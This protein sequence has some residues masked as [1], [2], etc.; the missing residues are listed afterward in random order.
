[1]P[2]IQATYVRQVPE[3]YETPYIV[4]ESTNSTCEAD[5]ADQDAVKTLKYSDFP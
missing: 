4:E 1:M 3:S 5:L 2:E